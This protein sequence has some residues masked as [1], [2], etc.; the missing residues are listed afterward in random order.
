[1]IASPA[2]NPATVMVV[3]DN[4]TNLQ[5]LEM[6]LRTRG[7]AVRSFT[8]GQA[9]LEAA[10]SQPPDVI[11]LD[12]AMPEMDGYE[13][14]RRL[15]TDERLATIPVI[16]I[17]ALSATRD[18]VK[19]FACGGVDYVTKPF[20]IEEVHARVETHHKL[21]QLQIQLERQ[22]D[23]LQRNYDQLR[24]LEE[25]RDNLTHM[26]V[27]DMRSPLAITQMSVEMLKARLTDLGEP[28]S[29][30][31]EGALRGAQTM[32]R[33]TTQLLDV[34]RLE[35][36]K[37]PLNKTACDLATVAQAAVEAIAPLLGD[38]R[39]V[40]DIR[41]PLTAHCD[42]ALLR[43][44]LDNL[45]SNALKF[46][47]PG[48]EITLSIAREGDS[49]QLAVM[50]AGPGIPEEYHRKIFEK[51][52]Q[53]ADE[54]QSKGTGLGLTFCKL[55]VEAHGGKIG[56][57]SEVGRGSTFWFT[58]PLEAKVPPAETSTPVAP[59]A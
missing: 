37:M 27:H 52:G 22:N 29:K 51:F 18:K 58:L 20:Q 31:L 21:R 38:R 45:M 23:E 42:A 8:R 28:E 10:A 26:V 17:S 36:G 43:R 41:E 12:I 56:V 34:S 3:D 15:K 32:N 54:Q 24:K 25:L 39:A 1:M 59:S 48:K 5:L 30:L 4:V 44:V 40:L 9:A 16:F 57:D 13:V 7:Y 14:C 35:A 49:A 50:D 33:M 11:L 47:P 2:P 46:A 55:A 19:G 6:L 53:I